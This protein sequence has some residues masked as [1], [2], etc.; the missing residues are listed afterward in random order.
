MPFEI[1][2]HFSWLS[3]VTAVTA[4]SSRWADTVACAGLGQEKGS[5]RDSVRRKE[6]IQIIQSLL[7][8]SG[9]LD[10]SSS[11]RFPLIQKSNWFY[12]QLPLPKY[13]W[14]G[15]DFRLD[16]YQNYE[17]FSILLHSSLLRTY[18]VLCTG[19]EWILSNP[20]HKVSLHL[21]A[22]AIKEN[23][24]LAIITSYYN[25]T[26]FINKMGNCQDNRTF[27]FYHGCPTYHRRINW[28]YCSL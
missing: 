1:F 5:G 6:F 21:L 4:L 13:L 28:Y 10:F 20:Y 16:N 27:S 2:T 19:Y 25:A 18:K 24:N 17:T 11:R 7:S 15:L 23:K 9:Y 22:Q 12:C 26:E 8:Q 14:L 3:L